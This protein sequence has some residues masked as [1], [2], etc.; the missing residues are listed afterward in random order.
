MFRH[1]LH[2]NKKGRAKNMGK[3]SQPDTRP[4]YKKKRFLIL[5]IYILLVFI[6][7]FLEAAKNNPA[8]NNSILANAMMLTT[9]QE[10]NI[11]DIFDNC[12]IGKIVKAVKFQGNEI[13]TSYHVNDEETGYYGD[14][15]NT[16][17]VWLNNKDKTVKS[18]YFNNRDIYIN[19]KVISK[20]T[21]H[22]IDSE[23]RTEYR[24][25]AQMYIEKFLNYPKT[26]KF[27]SASYWQFKV[28]D[29]GYD[30]IK[31]SVDAKNAF[32]VES[33]LAF[34]ISIDR[35]KKKPVS[36]ILNGREYLK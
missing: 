19:G 6:N 10:K 36:V 28:N 4:F 5:F 18:I 17:I 32:G 23:L 15:D 35:G 30:V 33:T 25:M 22:Y 9:E 26:A 8:Q 1:T 16:I 13:E 27:G 20:I 31:S 14:M 34:Q 2:K 3:N 29:A 12:G 21:D 7:L 24:T 11:R